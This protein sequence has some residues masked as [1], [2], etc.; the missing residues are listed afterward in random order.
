M[1]K[2]NNNVHD[3]AS[4]SRIRL[5]NSRK[6]D[7][8]AVMQIRCIEVYNDYF[9]DKARCL[10][11]N[12]FVMAKRAILKE[13][14]DKSKRDPGFSFRTSTRFYV[15]IP[16]S[17][18]HVNHPVG[19]SSTIGQYVDKRVVDKIYK[20]VKENITNLSEVQRSLDKYVAEELFS[21][22]PEERRPKKTNRRYYPGRRDLRNHI[23][24]ATILPWQF[25]Q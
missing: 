9:V 2:D 18:T 5:Q 23:A 25:Q 13:I 10:S 24:M 22:Q 3:Y 6:L 19:E 14:N 11:D 15:K 1:K 12:G 8:S 17:S 20:L 21:Y 7:C 4:K 16:L